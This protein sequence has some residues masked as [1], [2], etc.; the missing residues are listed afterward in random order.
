MN[1]RKTIST[2]AR[3]ALW[4][5]HGRKCAYTGE[6]LAWSELEI[7]HIIP[8]KGNAVR[9]TELIARGIV[10]ADFDINGFEN[11]LPT[12]A[13]LNNQ[14]SNFIANDAA[15]ALFL[16]L[17]AKAKEKV[18]R[19]LA[20]WLASDL[21]LKRYLQIK[22][23][24]ETNDISI[25]EMVTYLRHQFEGDVYLRVPPE[26]DGVAISTANSQF[27]A[28]LMD[29]PFALGRGS[30]TEV[31]LHSDN[32]E[33]TICTTANEFI[34][35]KAA[36]LWPKTQYDINCYG[37]ADQTSELLRA[38]KQSTYATNS[39]IRT[40]Q[41]T[42]KNLDRWAATW[43]TDRFC[44][45]EMD[46]DLS[47]YRTL[48]SLINAGIAQIEEQSEWSLTVHSDYGFSIQMRELM[49]A[50]LD[51]D[52]NEEILVFALAFAPKGTYRA[53]TVER[54]KVNDEGLLAPAPT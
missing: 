15:I 6:P 26:I 21:A 16:N 41:V 17:A 23:L 12:K 9:T 11:L 25:G 52:S 2:A 4:E 54:A 50:D 8:V 20:S 48:E 22:T 30:I 45:N 34:A 47:Q 53:S 24:A 37:L 19:L 36:G 42:L 51:S 14:K 35:A 43:V 46:I 1:E 7:D 38:V 44:P 31:A 27:A 29:K 33:V 49:R 13:Y 32:G 40:P 28:V 5:A 18:E 3:R 39:E 10:D